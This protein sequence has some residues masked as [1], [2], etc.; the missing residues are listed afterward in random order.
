MGG[1]VIA[2]R[3][4]GSDIGLVIYNFLLEEKSKVFCLVPS[5]KD[6]AIE[7]TEVL[8]DFFLVGAKLIDSQNFAH[9]CAC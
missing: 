8:I 1:L 9:D 7:G 3:L 2:V 6:L 5:I 4:K